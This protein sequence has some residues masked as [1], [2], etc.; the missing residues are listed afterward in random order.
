[1]AANQVK[2]DVGGNLNIE[3]LQD[4]STYTSAQKSAGGSIT[5][6][7]TFVPTGGGI[8][9]SKS[10]IDSN[11]QS[12]TQQSGIKA[13]D[14]GFQVDVKGNTDLKGAVIASTDTAVNE[15]LNTFTT[16]GTLTTSDIQ[17]TASY[18]GKAAGLSVDVGQQAGKYGVNGVG[19]GIGSDK[20]DAS[21]TSA[22]GISGIAGNTAVRSTDAET[23]IKPMFDADKVQR[24]IN[25]QVA[26]TQAFGKEA[27][28]AV[29]DY[30]EARLKDA[31]ALRV[32]AQN[33]PDKD[34]A[35]QLNAEAQA[36]EDNWGE[37]GTLR[38]LAHATIGGLTGGAG[39]ALGAAAGTLTAPTVAQALEDAGIDGPL[40]STLTALASTAAGAA[41]GGVAGG[42]AAAN[43]VMNN[44]LKHAE[45]SK[46]NTLTSKKIAGQCDSGCDKEISD[47]KALDEKR[48]QQLASCAS[49]A[50]AA[51][52]TARQDVRS[53]AA[54]YVRQ[55]SNGPNW[56]YI[57]EKN[58]TVRLAL[59]TMSGVTS[60][61]A[62]GALLAVKDGIVALGSAARTGFDAL[63]LLDPKAQILA[64]AGAG[65]AWDFV[66]DPANWPELMG[67]MSTADREKLAKAYETGD[68]LQVGLLMGAQ[69]SNL[70]GGGGM[71]TI[72]KIDKV[73]DATAAAAV[74]KLK[75][76]GLD[77]IK[78]TVGTKGSWERTI[79]GVLEPRTA[80][81]LDNGHT[82]VTDTAGRVNAVVAD[83]DLLKMDRNPYQQCTTG[84]CGNAGDQ[85]GHLIAATL[86]GAGDRVNL[87]PQAATLNNGP[88]KA[89]E[90]EF[91]AA[92]DGGKSVS[93]KID[94]GYPPG[95]GVRP[96][97]FVVTSMV[98][99]ERAVKR[100]YQ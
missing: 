30:A 100:F 19:V 78:A 28:K 44:Y 75:A 61:Q 73:L 49:T 23:G 99:G 27:S 91:K 9:A 50:S 41:V 92:L 16:V 65:A 34:K 45:A 74:V 63:V 53:A 31:T 29:G 22:A 80:Y 86:G 32:H 59:D 93:I 15:K 82:Y 54:E 48:N 8:S 66:K 88:W 37:K 68:G 98:D 47:L 97:E 46:L 25:A 38:V 43:E 42:A 40:A 20:G 71:G 2:A 95:G 70:P 57:N 11:Y 56:I 5:I 52:D 83:L 85:G 33:E 58:E 10:N 14:G 60:A 4:S 21:S 76:E 79:N 39:G 96:S 3:S 26:I 1:M 77:V 6:G 89:M 94:V 72:K 51:C 64:K 67:A 55:D 18:E 69:L 13:G 35:A 24:E 17:N 84:H 12:V 7:P 36:L 87:V 62:L 90:N 81:V